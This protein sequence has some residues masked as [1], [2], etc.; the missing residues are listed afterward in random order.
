MLAIHQHGFLSI[1]HHVEQMDYER[2]NVRF[3]CYTG[4]TIDQDNSFVDLVNQSVI[5]YTYISII[6]VKMFE[7]SNENL[8]SELR[9]QNHKLGRSMRINTNKWRLS[10]IFPMNS[11]K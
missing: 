6:H 5:W 10:F 9:I 4:K 7:L 8:L 11:N 3:L 1:L 2:I